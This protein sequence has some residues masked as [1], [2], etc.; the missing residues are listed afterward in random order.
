MNRHYFGLLPSKRSISQHFD[1]FRAISFSIVN[2]EHNS[3][4][5]V[6]CTQLCSGNTAHMFDT[7]ARKI[8]F[9]RQIKNRFSFIHE[10]KFQMR[11][12]MKGEF[13]LIDKDF[14]IDNLSKSLVVDTC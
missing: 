12:K 7:N 10:R 9:R 11:M 2:N 3:A 6:Y 5:N 4:V 14:F 13:L 1:C 8:L